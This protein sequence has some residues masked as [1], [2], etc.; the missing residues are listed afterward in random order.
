MA[1][2][3]RRGLIEQIK[4][5]E[6]GELFDKPQDIEYTTQVDFTLPEWIKEKDYVGRI[7]LCNLREGGSHIQESIGHECPAEVLQPEVSRGR[8]TPD[9]AR[10]NAECGV[11]LPELWGISSHI[12][13]PV[14]AKEL[15]AEVLQP[16]MSGRITA[17][18]KQPDVEEWQTL[19]KWLRGGILP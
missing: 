6:E 5:F 3:L 19:P 18:A 11:P 1:E 12:Q 2:R 15:H 7:H 16:E 4:V 8:E 9:K 14:N 17:G 10:P 13:E